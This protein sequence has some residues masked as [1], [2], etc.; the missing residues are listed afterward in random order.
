MG[1]LLWANCINHLSNRSQLCYDL[2]SNPVHLCCVIL[3]FSAVTCHVFKVQVHYL[4]QVE[5]HEFH[6]YDACM[7]ITGSYIICNYILCTDMCIYK[8]GPTKLST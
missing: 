4:K 5:R 3:V 2:T 7:E 8:V 1:G 6:M